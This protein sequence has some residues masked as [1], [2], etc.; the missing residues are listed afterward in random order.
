MAQETWIVSEPTVIDIEQL[1]SLKVGLIAGQVDIV[2][3]DA[4]GARVEVHSVSGRDLKV[5][6][7]GDRLIVDHP[8][9]RWDTFIDVFRHF[10]GSARAEVSILVPRSVAL[11][12]GVV[13]ATALIS[14][15]HDDASVSTVSGDVVIDRVVGDLQVNSVSGEISVRGHHGD[16]TAHT[17]SGDLTVSGEVFRFRG[18]GVS[19]DYFLDL[20]GSPDLVS[21]KTVSGDATVRL[22]AGRPAQYLVNTISGKLQL[23]DAHIIGVRGQ[24]S[25]KFGDLHG[26]FTEVRASTVSGNVSVVHAERVDA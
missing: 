25:G 8:Q 12:F 11:T 15:L 1:S 13:S 16:V 23:D 2:A 10:R 6:L 4:P 21:V 5:A 7:E 26:S 20:H 19:S 18:D 22:D 3:H 17:V 14:G 24:H 9:L